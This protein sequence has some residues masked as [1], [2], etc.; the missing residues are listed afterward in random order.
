EVASSY[1]A[2]PIHFLRAE[3]AILAADAKFR[4]AQRW[5]FFTV[6]ALEYKWQEKFAWAEV[7][8]GKNWDAG[9]VLSM[10]NATELRE[11]FDN[12]ELW[13]NNRSA[14][15][16]LP[17]IAIIS[18][19]DHIFAPNPADP[20]LLFPRNPTGDAVDRG[21]RRDPVTGDLI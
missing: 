13:N 9:S 15:A 2:D 18:L 1:F 21:K 20:N 6:R 16:D 10:R 11:M 17:D 3:Q 8:L 14:G 5:V 12:M 19:R 7:A 4:L